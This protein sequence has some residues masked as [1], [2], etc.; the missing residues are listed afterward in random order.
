MKWKQ[1]CVKSKD[2]S[3]KCKWKGFPGGSVVQ[4]LSAVQ[5]TGV[6][7]LGR[8]KLLEK[9]T[10]T[11]SSI[12]A[13]RISWTEEPGGLQSMGLQKADTAEQPNNEGALLW[14]QLLRG[15]RAGHPWLQEK[16][17]CFSSPQALP[18]DEVFS[19][20]PWGLC[21]QAGHSWPGRAWET[22][23]TQACSVQ[24]GEFP[25]SSKQSKELML[26]NCDVGED[27]WESLG[28]QRDPASPS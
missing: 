22:K 14:R 21:R 9:E 1:W 6:W 28:L 20:H 25:G 3:V 2:G 7:S 19:Q 17:A 10:A 27:S 26:L 12:L 11:H 15:G 13:R 16:D 4:N 18:P 8:E 24:D 5:E 23:T